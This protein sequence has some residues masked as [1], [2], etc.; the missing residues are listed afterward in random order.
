MPPVRV[1]STFGLPD[2]PPGMSPASVLMLPLAQPRSPDDKARTARSAGFEPFMF[3]AGQGRRWEEKER[4]GGRGKLPVL[5]ATAGDKMVATVIRQ[6]TKEAEVHPAGFVGPSGRP[7][8]GK[9]SGRRSSSGG[10]L[11]IRSAVVLPLHRLVLLGCAD[12][13]VRVGT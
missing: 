7:V 6:D 4:R 2:S 3:G 13:W 5:F 10:G 11:A 8:T 9:S 1:S 12:G